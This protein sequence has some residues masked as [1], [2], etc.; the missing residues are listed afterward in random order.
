M[1]RSGRWRK[2]TAGR[3]EARA[4][5]TKAKLDAAMEA[6]DYTSWSQE[7]LIERVTQLEAELKSKNLRF[8]VSSLASRIFIINYL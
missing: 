4:A 1:S 5:T 3:K 2:H 6:A 7:K 8:V